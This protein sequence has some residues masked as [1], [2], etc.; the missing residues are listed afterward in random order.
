[1]TDESDRTFGGWLWL[2]VWLC[3]CSLDDNTVDFIG[4]SYLNIS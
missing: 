4:C 1:M 3:K 2:Y